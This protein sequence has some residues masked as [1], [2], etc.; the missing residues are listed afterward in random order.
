[1]EQKNQNLKKY[2]KMS[3][4]FIFVMT[5]VLA[6][7]FTAL[8]TF[9]IENVKKESLQTYSEFCT[10]LA[11]STAE[12]ITYWINALTKNL[13]VYTKDDINKDGNVSEIA[14]WIKSNKTLVASEFGYTG[15]CD[16][17][18]KMYTSLGKVTDIHD[19]PFFKAIMTDLNQTN[20]DNPVVSR[21]TGDNLF[22]ITKA[23]Y[24]KNGKLFGCYVGTV[25]LATLQRLTDK[26]KVG[27]EGY[28]FVVGG[29]GTLIAHKD[30]TFIM[31]NQLQATDEQ[32]GVIGLNAVGHEMINHKTGIGTIKELKTG[33][34]SYVYY[35]P[36][37]NTPWSLGL[38]VPKSQIMHSAYTLRNF[39][40]VIS[41]MVALLIV[42]VCGFF[43][44]KSLMPLGFVGKTINS[45][46]DGD[47]D[48]TQKLRISSKNEIAELVNGFNRF[49]EKL[50]SI[51]S[52]IKNSK[53]DLGSVDGELQSS[54]ADTASSITQ[55]L[56][57]IESVT[58]QVE[59]Q[60]ASVEETAGAVHEIAQNIES[61][62]HMIQTQ[63]SGVSQAGA[64]VEQMIGNI[65]AVDGSMT[66]MAGAFSDLEQNTE[67][68][69]A[70]QKSVNER[71]QQI[72]DQS[73]MLQDANKA[74][75]AIASQTNLLAMN[76]AIEAAHAG[77][78]GRGFSV[79]A[80]EIRKLSETSTNQSKT[81]GAEL[82]KIRASIAEVVENSNETTTL[83][84]SVSFHISQTDE[85][86]QQ[87][88]GAMQEQ[89]SGSK[90]ITGALKM[91]MDSTEEVRT[92]S[93]EMAEGN[94]AI[95]DEIKLLQEATVAIKES[96][97]EMS[98][99]AKGINETSSHLTDISHKME[100][101]IKSIG[102]EIDLF[103]V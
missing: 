87:I 59:G 54:I 86:V 69:I 47:A 35:V 16:K 32:S 100:T 41:G 101:S 6:V 88:K 9:I 21:T 79:V 46:A 23:A 50:H 83:F 3:T 33:V 10:Q 20:I 67:Q 96:M 81:I 63:A 25:S 77:D 14:N 51:I 34:V 55:I 44:S 2:G 43:I 94:K 27:I 48:L 89:Q 31:Q 49:V 91:M 62:E 52:R 84:N 37:N 58:K 71:I 36:I 92:A 72:E 1:M 45:I 82:K 99:G 78:A 75:S 80:D 28:A 102:G 57:N 60:A 56:A 97:A 19:R 13:D 24:D 65:N 93:R 40:I 61:L 42:I 12:N 38:T 4:R 68:G 22:H 53:D 95:L 76:A 18:G 70:H 5:V 90:Q 15:F 11:S 17:D 73:A 98:A 103:K 39:I 29:V 74:I 8:E 66:K 26:V 64:A 30:K 7:F 85:L